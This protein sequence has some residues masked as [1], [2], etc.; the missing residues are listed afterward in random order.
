MKLSGTTLHK[1]VFEEYLHWWDTYGAKD[2]VKWE[3]EVEK[4]IF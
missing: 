2:S 1:G 4:L 3:Q